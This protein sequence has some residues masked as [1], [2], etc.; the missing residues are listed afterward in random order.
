MQA[1]GKGLATMLLFY[2]V[3]YSVAKL[4]NHFCVPDTVY[5]F[6]QGM[7]STGSPVCMGGMEILKSTQTS[8]ASLIM[9]G[10]SRLFVDMITP[11]NRNQNNKYTSTEDPN[12]S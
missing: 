7:I 1:I 5:G 10:T 4:Y 2:S 6:F 8:Y 3:H 11:F 12:A 9:L